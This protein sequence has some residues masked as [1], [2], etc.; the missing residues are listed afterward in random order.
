MNATHRMATKPSQSPTWEEI[1][2][3][4]VRELKNGYQTNHHRARSIARI[5]R[6]LRTDGTDAN[7]GREGCEYG[8]E[9]YRASARARLDRRQG[10]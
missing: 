6:Q 1:E 8:R 2:G 5:L 9:S 4:L 3:L 7:T 10:P